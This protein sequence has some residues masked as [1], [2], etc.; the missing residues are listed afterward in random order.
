MT[1]V[2]KVEFKVGEISLD[3]DTVLEKIPE[4]V[5]EDK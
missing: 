5:K 2:T 3:A 4:I 1:N